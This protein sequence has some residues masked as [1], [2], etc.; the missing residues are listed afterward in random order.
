MFSQGFI[1]RLSVVAAVI[2]R[3]TG[4]NTPSSTPRINAPATIERKQC[5]KLVLQM[6]AANNVEDIMSI[7]V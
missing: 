4:N 6:I 3:S 1:A 5:H 7:I 2:L